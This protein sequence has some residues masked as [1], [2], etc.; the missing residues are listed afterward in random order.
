MQSQF[1]SL[2]T[3]LNESAIKHYMHIADCEKCEIGKQND[4]C[5]LAQEQFKIDQKV[6]LNGVF[7]AQISSSDRQKLVVELMQEFCQENYKLSLLFLNEMYTKMEQG[8]KDNIKGLND[9]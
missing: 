3:K 2:K 5:Q 7:E 6:D 4:Q 1:E 9:E 8:E